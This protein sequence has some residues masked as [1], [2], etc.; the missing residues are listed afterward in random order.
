MVKALPP[1]PTDPREPD[2]V[3]DL[4]LGAIA[5]AL[6]LARSPKVFCEPG[7]NLA[8]RNDLLDILDAYYPGWR[9]YRVPK[10]EQYARRKLCLD[11]SPKRP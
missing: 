10:A 1:K 4:Q 3:R 8:S 11:E 2:P 6:G 9:G 5:H 7:H